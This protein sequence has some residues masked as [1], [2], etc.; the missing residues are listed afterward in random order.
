MNS[1]MINVVHYLH[2]EPIIAYSSGTH[3]SARY[4]V[5]IA[6]IWNNSTDINNEYVQKHLVHDYFT[7]IV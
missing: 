2:R 1:N 5:N 7:H 6:N 3:S 4:S